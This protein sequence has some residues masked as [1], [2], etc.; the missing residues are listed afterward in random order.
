MLLMM[1]K[2]GTSPPEKKHRKDVD[3]VKD[4]PEFQIGSAHRIGNNGGVDERRRRSEQRA[5]DR[6]PVT[7]PE[8]PVLQNDRIV[9]KRKHAGKKPH[10]ADRIVGTLIETARQDIDDRIDAEN[11]EN[12]DH[13]GQNDIECPDAAVEF[14]LPETGKPYLLPLGV[15][16]E[17][18]SDSRRR[19]GKQSAEY[20]EQNVQRAIGL[21]CPS[22]DLHVGEISKYEHPEHDRSDKEKDGFFETK[23]G[24]AVQIGQFFHHVSRSPFR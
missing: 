8:I 11:A 5:G 9:F 17:K 7:H 13:N 6:D 14:A 18:K 19:N 22:V 3:P 4:T 2:Y 10:A 24:I 1:R 21:L 20:V 15:H 16:I 12:P 23:I